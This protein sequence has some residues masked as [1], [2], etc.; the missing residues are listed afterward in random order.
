M[1]EERKIEK[2]LRAYAKKRRAGAGDP[3]KLD[4][5][6]RRQLQAAA[7][8][9]E[10]KPDEDESLSLWQLF[11]QQWVF[12]VGFALVMFFLAAMFLPALT[13]SKTKF[14]SMNALGNLKE[15]GLAAQMA[16][17]DAKGSLPAS[18]D[19]LTNQYVS[20]AVLTD[21]QSGKRFI[22]AVGGKNL[23]LL[24]SNT[25]LAY[26]PEDRNGRAVLLADGTVEQASRERFKELTNA[27]ALA[28]A[29]DN[30]VNLTAGSSPGVSPNTG[31]PMAETPA[32]AS[33][34]A[35][36]TDN[37]ATDKMSDVP[38][39]GQLAVQTAASTFN[40][41]KTESIQFGS[42]AAQLARGQI[43]ALQNSFRN[44]AVSLG[45]PVVLANF[46]VQQTGNAIRVLDADGS[47]YDGAVI[48]YDA[49]AHRTPETPEM[50]PPVVAPPAAQAPAATQ[51]KMVGP[52]AAL[53]SQENSAR[54]NYFFRVAGLNR[55]LKQN[56]VFTGSLMMTST[57]LASGAGEIEGIGGG[58]TLATNS[59]IWGQVHALQAPTQQLSQNRP[60][61]VVWSNARIAGTAVVSDT[62]I[63][64]IDATSP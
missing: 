33:A 34:P 7:R 62:N 43:G 18:L 27:P 11:R 21:P 10:A 57:N 41:V 22:Y 23:G 1:D 19:A 47:V 35:P 64:K 55:T 20:A 13:S 24:P 17:G 48:D 3:L 51:E 30:G 39:N 40:A 32:P 6:M 25:V 54:Q 45:R 56:V 15:I 44:N 37:L 36:P 16:A 50:T 38:A 26:S 60:Q 8:R 61:S 29:K 42:S 58:G 59:L 4:P 31:L 9:R 2:L 12:L 63:I 53:A 49:T 28:L 52:V 46:L 5:A 14:Q